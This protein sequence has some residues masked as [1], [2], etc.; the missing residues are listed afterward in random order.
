MNT[1]LSHT[2]PMTKACNTNELHGPVLLFTIQPGTV[3][4]RSSGSFFSVALDFYQRKILAILLMVRDVFYMLLKMC[5]S[6][7]GVSVL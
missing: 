7:C 4:L 5:M 3:L 1:F 6:V 2:M